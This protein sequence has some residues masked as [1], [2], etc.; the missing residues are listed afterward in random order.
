[1]FHSITC[2]PTL[3]GST[4][5]EL[6]WIK[7]FHNTTTRNMPTSDVKKAVSHHKLQNMT[8]VVTKTLCH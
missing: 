7:Q 1:M 6:L 4:T 8:M 3:G 5:S 2:A